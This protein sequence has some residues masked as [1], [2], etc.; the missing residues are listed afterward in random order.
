MLNL[1]VGREELVN[2]RLKGSVVD[3]ASLQ[4]V[5]LELK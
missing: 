2:L 5:A 4:G 3:L 1:S